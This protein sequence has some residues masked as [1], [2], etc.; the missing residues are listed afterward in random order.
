MIFGRTNNY[1]SEQAIQEI[2]NTVDLADENERTHYLIL[3]LLYE[4]GAHVHEILYLSVNDIDL[5]DQLIMLKIGDTTR[6]VSISN[7]LTEN[8]LQ[9]IKDNNLPKAERLFYPGVNM[10][11]ANLCRVLRMY[12]KRAR[13]RHP[14]L[15]PD[16]DSVYSFRISR[17]NH[18][19]Q[20][21]LSVDELRCFLGHDSI[22]QTNRYVGILF[23]IPN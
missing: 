9:H 10:S 1:F 18:L 6:S 7:H 8:I 17:A 14:R 12:I 2:L 3:N 13:I 21:G 19:Y 5:T 11:C 22:N 23:H 16:F 15:I 20:A 4:T